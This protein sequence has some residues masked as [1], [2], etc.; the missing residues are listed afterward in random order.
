MGEGDYPHHLRL[1]DCYLACGS[2]GNRKAHVEYSDTDL[3]PQEDQ[4]ALEAIL[5]AM[6]HCCHR[7]NALARRGEPEHVD[8]PRHRRLIHVKINATA[9]SATPGAPP[10]VPP[11]STSTSK[12]RPPQLVTQEL[13]LDKAK[14]S[15]NLHREELAE[16]DGIWHLGTV[17][18]NFTINSYNLFANSVAPIVHD[19]QEAF[20]VVVR[21]GPDIWE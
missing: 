2:R 4:M 13:D 1:R 17:H 14:V 16:D 8:E 21:I 11:T 12:F 5:R 6:P 20:T 7:G 9:R 15:A 10:H 19:E 18:E 3:A